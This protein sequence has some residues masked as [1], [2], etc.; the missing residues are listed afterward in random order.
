MMSVFKERYAKVLY[1]FYLR[2]VE[3]YLKCLDWLHFEVSKNNLIVRYVSLDVVKTQF[4][5]MDLSHV[6]P[7]KWY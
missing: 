7:S 2:H 6:F 1:D 3:A 5:L 4:S